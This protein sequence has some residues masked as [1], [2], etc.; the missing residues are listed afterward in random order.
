MISIPLSLLPFKKNLYSRILSD[1]TNQRNYTKCRHTSYNI[2]KKTPREEQLTLPGFPQT[3]FVSTRKQKRKQNGCIKNRN[4]YFFG[5]SGTLKSCKKNF[6]YDLVGK[7]KTISIISLHDGI[8]I[9]LG[10]GRFGGTRSKCYFHIRY[11][12]E[13]SPAECRC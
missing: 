3:P 10:S 2:R 5:G 7:V 13:L 8:T 1:S 6:S 4:L 9:T 12:C 11:H